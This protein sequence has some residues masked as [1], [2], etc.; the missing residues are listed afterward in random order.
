MPVK[1]CNHGSTVWR[2]HIC[3]RAAHREYQRRWVERNYRRYRT[4]QERWKDEHID[5]WRKYLPRWR[6]YR[7]KVLGTQFTERLSNTKND[8]ILLKLLEGELKRL[9]L[10]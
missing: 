2:C 10:K 4:E 1:Y 8:Y 9:K 5:Y 3:K 6:L 7:N